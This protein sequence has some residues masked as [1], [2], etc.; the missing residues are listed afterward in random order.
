MDDYLGEKLDK[1][2]DETHGKLDIILKRQYVVDNERLLLGL[3]DGIDEKLGALVKKQEEIDDHL[4]LVNGN[5]LLM[6][7]N[8]VERYKEYRQH[9]GRSMNHTSILLKRCLEYM[10]LKKG[11]TLVEVARKLDIH[12]STVSAYM[13]GFGIERRSTGTQK[14]VG[15]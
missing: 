5:I 7:R 11:M 4:N 14:K 3:Q 13:Q 8:M 12:Y 15:D 2:Q 10:Y 9:L 1:M 6:S